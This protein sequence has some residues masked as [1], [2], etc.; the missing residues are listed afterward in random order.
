MKADRG[1]SLAGDLRIELGDVRALGVALDRPAGERRGLGWR[2]RGGRGRDACGRVDRHLA[3]AESQG[4]EREE[5]YEAHGPIVA[6][7][8]LTRPRRTAGSGR[9]CDR[10]ARTG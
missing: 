4:G 3:G 10:A 9:G 1:V 8:E 7:G 2:G 5:G 6:R